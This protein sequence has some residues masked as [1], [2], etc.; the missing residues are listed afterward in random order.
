MQLRH[1]RPSPIKNKATAP[2]SEQEIVNL[3]TQEY[4]THGCFSLKINGEI[5]THRIGDEIKRR[6]G[7]TLLIFTTQNEDGWQKDVE[8]PASEFSRLAREKY[9]PQ[10]KD[11]CCKPCL[12]L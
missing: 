2:K 5:Y 8:I 12:I 4:K 7:E 1:F 6:G 9:F 3:I 11:E 10:P